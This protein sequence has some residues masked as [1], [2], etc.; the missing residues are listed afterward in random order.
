MSGS[1]ARP[2]VARQQIVDSL[3]IT[4]PSFEQVIDALQ[5]ASIDAAYAANVPTDELMK[6]AELSLGKAYR[7]VRDWRGQ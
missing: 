7:A 1:F 4:P 2:S 3:L 6:D 5:I